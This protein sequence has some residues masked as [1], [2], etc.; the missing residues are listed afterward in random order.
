MDQLVAQLHFPVLLWLVSMRP[1]QWQGCDSVGPGFP[2]PVGPGWDLVVVLVWSRA[3]AD[4]GCTAC[5]H[6][7]TPVSWIMGLGP[8]GKN[9]KA[10][11]VGNLGGQVKNLGDTSSSREQTGR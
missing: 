9:Y 11:S 5:T 10:P 8:S 4:L 2:G 1:W 7:P 3:S 6:L